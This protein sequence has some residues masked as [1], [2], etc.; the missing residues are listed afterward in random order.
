MPVFRE[1]L[2]AF[3]DLKD[4]NGLRFLLTDEEIDWV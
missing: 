3:I 1:T 4:G 2:G